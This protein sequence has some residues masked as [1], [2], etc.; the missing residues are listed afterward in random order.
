MTTENDIFVL[1]LWYIEHNNPCKN[2]T[3]NVFTSI[4][5]TSSPA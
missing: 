1:P 4:D 2:N 5:V 3:N